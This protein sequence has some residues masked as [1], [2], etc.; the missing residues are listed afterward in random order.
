MKSYDQKQN[1]FCEIN[2]SQSTA[3]ILY[4]VLLIKFEVNCSRVNVRLLTFITTFY[5]E[6]AH[7]L[8]VFY[9][10]CSSHIFQN[11]PL[12]K[13]LIANCHSL[14]KTKKSK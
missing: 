6:N 8:F 10:Q 14:I 1:V 5:Y 3:C 4:I 2:F 13:T 7:I 9:L 11:V 12:W